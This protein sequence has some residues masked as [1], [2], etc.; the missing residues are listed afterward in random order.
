M[1]STSKADARREIF[2]RE[3]LKDLNATRAAIAAGYSEKTARA[4]ASRLLTNVDIKKR[5]EEALA[6][7]TD[8]LDITVERVLGELSKLAFANMADCTK[9]QADGSA[10]VDLSNLTREQ[11]AAVQ[12]ITSE[13]FVD[14]YEGESEERQPVH[15]KR[16]KFKLADKR[17]SLELLGKYLK[18]FG[19]DAGPEHE[20]PVVFNLGNLVI[21]GGQ[22][23]KG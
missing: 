13:V 16:T 6:K 14:H 21:R 7:K 18:L 2:I 12:E 1:G 5:V 10:Y 15:V 22:D 9:A 19:G 20:F 8:K 4:A 23:A 3:Y 11:W 17:G